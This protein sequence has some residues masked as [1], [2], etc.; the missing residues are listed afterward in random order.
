MNENEY[1][2]AVSDLTKA[3]EQVKTFAETAKTELKNLG[4]VTK[5]TKASADKALTEM[6]VLAARLTDLEQKGA[7]GHG[8]EQ[9][10]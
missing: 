3:T 7:R 8:N 4:E 5:E 6:N 9:Q 1:K 10:V 2:Q